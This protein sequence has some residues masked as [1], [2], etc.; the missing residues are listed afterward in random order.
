MSTLIPKKVQE[1]ARRCK[2]VQEGA[3]RCKKVQ[4]GARRSRR[5]VKKVPQEYLTQHFE[6]AARLNVSQRQLVV[7]MPRPKVPPKSAP[8]SA[9]GKKVPQEYLGGID[10]SM[11]QSIHAADSDG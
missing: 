10:A 6:P 1:G 8:K 9:E 5:C 11:F 2:K 4:E 7:P 3:R